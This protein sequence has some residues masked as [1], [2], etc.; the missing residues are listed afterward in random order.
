MKVKL[1]CI[2]GGCAKFEDDENLTTVDD[3]NGDRFIVQQQSRQWMDRHQ[4]C[5]E[6]DDS[7][8]YELPNNVVLH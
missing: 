6:F 4:Q 3:K 7:E 1:R 2:C 8:G 5:A